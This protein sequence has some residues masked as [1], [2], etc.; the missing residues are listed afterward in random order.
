M[1]KVEDGLHKSSS[2]VS[3]KMCLL[4][5]SIIC[6]LFKKFKEEKKYIY[7][8]SK[9]HVIFILKHINL[10]LFFPKILLNIFQKI[11]CSLQFFQNILQ[12][13]FHFFFKSGEGGEDMDLNRSSVVLYYSS[14]ESPNPHHLWEKLVQQPHCI[15]Q[16]STFFLFQKLSKWHLFPKLLRIFPLCIICGRCQEKRKIIVQK[17]SSL[18]QSKFFISSVLHN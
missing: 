17:I 15:F 6:K 9:G 7:I 16:V 18:D 13:Y 5:Y 3:F 14:D 10:Q 4:F 8:C 12:F 2:Y 11:V 1:L